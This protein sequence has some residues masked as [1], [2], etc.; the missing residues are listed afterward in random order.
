M[1]EWNQ[2]NVKG[3]LKYNLYL[4]LYDLQSEH[5]V[6]SITW[7][8]FKLVQTFMLVSGSWISLLPSFNRDG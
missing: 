1:N 3:A 5:Q 7:A 8:S 6:S 4:E 2:L